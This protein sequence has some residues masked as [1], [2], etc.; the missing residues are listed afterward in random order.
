VFYLQEGWERTLRR[1]DIEL[2]LLKPDAPLLH[3]LGREPGWTR[4]Y[5]DSVAV[6]LR[7]STPDSAGVQ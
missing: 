7:R 6:L 4:W 3:A 2:V 5:G 1:R